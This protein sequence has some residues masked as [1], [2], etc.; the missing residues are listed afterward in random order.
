M[1][2]EP[3][4]LPQASC[5]QI[6]HTLPLQHARLRLLQFISHFAEKLLPV[7]VTT[8]STYSELMVSY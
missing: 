1:A 8:R 5:H 4:A 6:N 2:R 7:P 3:A